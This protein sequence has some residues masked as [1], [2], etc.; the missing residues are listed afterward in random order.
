MYGR[1][2]VWSDPGMGRHDLPDRIRALDPER[3]HDHDHAEIYRLTST[4]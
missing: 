2:Q 1:R 3:D 4:H